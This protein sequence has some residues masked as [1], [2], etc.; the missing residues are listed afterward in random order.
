[1]WGLFQL[2]SL[3]ASL[4][5]G[6]LADAYDPQ[7][8]FWS[9]LLFSPPRVFLLLL[10]Y[11]NEMPSDHLLVPVAAAARARVIMIDFYFIMRYLQSSSG[12]V[13]VLAA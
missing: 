1:M 13:A 11:L 10:R 12:P 5:V 4:F 6:P 7:I 9:L 2:G 3:T 8:I